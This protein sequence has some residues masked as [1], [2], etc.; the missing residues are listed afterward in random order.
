MSFIDNLLSQIDEVSI[1]ETTYWDKCTIKRYGPY[2]KPNGA[3]ATGEYPVYE[4][5]KCAVSKKSTG[6]I[7]QTDTTNQAR[8]ELCLF[9]RPDIDIKL[10]DKIEVTYQN[11]RED[12]FKAG[13]PFYYS[14]HAEIPLIKEGIA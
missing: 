8:Y 5:I 7:I 13:E 11:N 6:T 9:I 1:L 2:K 3:T 12:K 4:N 10:G 14:S